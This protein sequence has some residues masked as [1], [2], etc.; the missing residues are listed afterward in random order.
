MPPGH[1]EQNHR[2]RRREFLKRVTRRGAAVVIGLD[3]IGLALGGCGKAASVLTEP[4]RPDRRVWLLSDVHA[5]YWADR[6]DGADWLK[7]AVQ[8]L[9]DNVQDV[10]YAVCLGDMTHQSAAAGFRKYTEVRDAAHLGRWYELAGNHDYRAIQSGL[11]ARYVK[12]PLRSVVL[13]GSTAWFL[14]SAQSGGSAGLISQDGADWLCRNIQRHQADKN[15]IVCSHHLVYNTV[16]YSKQV[17]RYLHPKERVADVLKRVRVDLWLCG[18]AH[19]RPRTPDCAATRGRT[20][21]VNVA[22]VSHAYGTRM[23]NSCLLEVAN[24]SRNALIRCRDHD[25]GRYLAEHDVRV[26][27]PHPWNLG[28]PSEPLPGVAPATRPA[29]VA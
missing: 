14:V 12:S 27:F 19:S 2:M 1:G 17:S 16:L 13:D 7:M 18:H 20:T 6:R 24:G 15:I 11:Y 4:T 21:F 28:Q 23:A 5:A 29:A 25:R 22:S 3:G 9:R 10:A 8:D 26:T